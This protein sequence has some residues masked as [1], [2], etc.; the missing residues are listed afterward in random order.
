[1]SVRGP[2]LDSGAAPLCC[3]SD[4][5]PD[6]DI[7]HRIF[8]SSLQLRFKRGNRL[9]GSRACWVVGPTLGLYVEFKLSLHATSSRKPVFIILITAVILQNESRAAE[10]MDSSRP[11]FQEL[12]VI[13]V[14]CYLLIVF[15]S[16]EGEGDSPPM[17]TG[18]TFSLSLD[19]DIKLLV[20][21]KATTKTTVASSSTFAASYFWSIKY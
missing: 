21:C 15:S 9:D 4:G 13:E 3:G 12:S 19:P 1:M 5:E 18:Q 8:P 17:Q 6:G 16:C 2:V 20:G 7:W 11:T 14:T 10:G